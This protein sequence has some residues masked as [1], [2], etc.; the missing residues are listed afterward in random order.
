MHLH[1]VP[2]IYAPQ[3][4]INPAYMQNDVGIVVPF[5]GAQP[6]IHQAPPSMGADVYQMVDR[7]SSWI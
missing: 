1:A 6:P 2:R 4:S 7:Y 5:Q 3:N